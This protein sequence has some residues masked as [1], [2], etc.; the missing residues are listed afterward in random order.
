VTSS[1]AHVH[2]GDPL[3]PAE[4]EVLHLLTAGRQAPQIATELHLSLDGAKSRLARIYRKLEAHTAAQAVHLAHQAGLLGTRPERRHGDH[5]GYRQHERAG[6]EFCK[7]CIAA[8][9]AYRRARRQ[10]TTTVR[11]A[12]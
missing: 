8:E 11:S 10:T 4:L 1:L 3:T 12:A 2:P 5:A 7:P 6:D 9:Q